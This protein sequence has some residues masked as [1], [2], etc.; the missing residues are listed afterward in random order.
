MI[1]K[2]NSKQRKCWSSLLNDNRKRF[3]TQVFIFEIKSESLHK[4]NYNKSCI[5]GHY[6]NRIL[7]FL[8]KI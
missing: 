4:N 6:I 7:L 2:R 1:Q 3:L 5:R 8:S